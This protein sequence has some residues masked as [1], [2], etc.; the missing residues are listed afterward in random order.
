MSFFLQNH[1]LSS[2]NKWKVRKPDKFEWINIL[3]LKCQ[4]V[5]KQTPWV[6]SDETPNGRTTSLC[7]MSTASTLD[8]YWVRLRQAVVTNQCNV[9]GVLQ[10]N[11]VNP[12][13]T[14]QLLR[15]QSITHFPW[16]RHR[17]HYRQIIDRQCGRCFDAF[18]SLISNKSN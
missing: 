14:L 7:S 2:H 16:H 17:Y 18:W 8:H 1:D 12:R 3:S 5:A 10:Y 6:W 9:S 4:R 15:P 13:Q 11:V